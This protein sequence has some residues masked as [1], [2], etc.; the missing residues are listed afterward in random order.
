MQNICWLSG[1]ISSMIAGVLHGGVDKWIYIDIDDQ[2]PDTHRFIFDFEWEK[3]LN[4]IRMKSPYGDVETCVRAFGGF[5]NA[6]NGFAPCTNWL[7]KRMRKQFELK[8]DD[9]NLTYIW[10]FDSHETS[11]AERIVEAN[12]HADHVFPLIDEGIK[13]EECHAIFQELFNFDRPMM[14]TLGYPNNNCVGCVK[15]G[16]GYWN[17]I[18]KDF[19]DVFANRAKLERELGVSMLKD[20]NGPVF[21]DELDPARGRMDMEI[22]PE[23]GV[24]CEFYKK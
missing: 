12:P 1:G 17:K 7:K 18:R 14:Y 5:R 16:M 10:G 4:V 24:M 8:N 23:C 19:P 2:H 11:R 6:H 22:F 13:K 15:G 9:K 3:N 20:K 21:L